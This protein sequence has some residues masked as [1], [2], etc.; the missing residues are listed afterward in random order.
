MKPLLFCWVLFLRFHPMPR[1][2]LFAADAERFRHQKTSNSRAAKCTRA[3]AVL[4]H[5][6]DAGERQRWQDDKCSIGAALDERELQSSFKN[7]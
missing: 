4:R 7:L 3:Q 6:R 2:D 1:P 5:V